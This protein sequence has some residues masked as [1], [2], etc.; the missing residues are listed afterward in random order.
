MTNT[1]YRHRTKRIRANQVYN[2]YIQD[3]NHI[4]MNSTR[5]TT[6]TEFS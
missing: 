1:E 4:H 2:E 3:R 6:L 5:W